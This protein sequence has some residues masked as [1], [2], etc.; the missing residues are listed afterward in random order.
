M[1]LLARLALDRKPTRAWV[2]Y[3]WANSAFIT[4]VVAAVFPPW[5]VALVE[6]AGDRD[7]TF[8]LS[9]GT[10]IALTV[11]ALAS[12]LLGA[13]ADHAPIKKRMVAIFTA[14]GATAT[15]CLWFVGDGDWR[16]ALLLFAVGNIA[17]NGAFVFYDSLLPHVASR[18]E[19]DRVSTAGYALGYLGGGLLLAVSVVMILSPDTVGLPDK[20]TAIRLSF[21]MT[22]VWWVVFAIPLLRHVPE[23]VVP[24]SRRASGTA[25]IRAGLAD[26]RNTWRE[27]RK[28]PQAARM[29]VA[30]LIYND[31]VGTIIRMATAYGE[32]LGLGTGNLITAL[33]IVQFVGIP[34]SFA[35]G[36]VAGRIGTRRAIFVG[37]GAYCVVSVL[38]YFMT[39][40]LHFYVLAGLVGLVQGGVQA[41]SR[42]LF[43]SMIPRHRSSEFFGLFAVF[44]KFAGIL[45]PAMFALA[46]AVFG[47]SRPAIL[48]VIGFFVVGGALLARVDV[49]AGQRAASE[50][51]ALPSSP[52]GVS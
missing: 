31:G 30:F 29:L 47:S 26:L 2:M 8:K 16:L 5:F 36:H 44:E 48:S 12:P 7:A 46:I 51:N 41:L 9:L 25:A 38:G 52:P 28:L 17:A 50:A 45:G 43:A 42:S 10:A 15:A 27:L 1:G 20:G 34:A 35:F 11:I 4:I 18:D 14:I 22:A 24:P 39:T 13:I 23:P 33:L 37:L 40:A 21:V 3:D 32:E 6:G 49:A 19:L